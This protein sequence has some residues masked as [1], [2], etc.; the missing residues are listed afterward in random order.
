M[1]E[2]VTIHMNYMFV[3]MYD[4]GLS[5]KVKPEFV[6][7]FHVG[8]TMHVVEIDNFGEDDEAPY[9]LWIGLDAY[10][11]PITE[12]FSEDNVHLMMV[13]GRFKAFK[14]HVDELLIKYGRGELCQN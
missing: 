13:E 7:R 2:N 1:K 6:E 3:V 8:V 12:Y 9:K 5:E 14:K 10:G 4:R 11:E